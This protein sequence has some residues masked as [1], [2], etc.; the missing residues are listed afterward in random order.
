M[1][2]VLIFLLS[3]FATPVYQLR[4]YYCSLLRFGI[5]LVLWAT[6][7][8]K[9]GYLSAGIARSCGIVTC[10]QDSPCCCAAPCWFSGW[11]AWW[12]YG[13]VARSGAG[14]LVGLCS[15]MSGVWVSLSY[16]VRCH[17][18]NHSSIVACSAS[19]CQ[20]GH[21]DINLEGGL[22]RCLEYCHTNLLSLTT[23]VLSIVSSTDQRGQAT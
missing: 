18:S 10:H 3:V 22:C 5:R 14:M 23:S 7:L 21:L 8:C 11:L 20:C 19:V 9:D 13:T 4:L 6:Y 17:T 16:V 2:A 1:S 12:C 15:L